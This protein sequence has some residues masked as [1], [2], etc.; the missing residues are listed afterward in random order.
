MGQKLLGLVVGAS[1]IAGASFGDGVGA[2]VVKDKPPVATGEFQLLL[3]GKRIGEERFRVFKGKKDYRV[4]STITLYWPGPSQQQYEWKLDRSFQPDELTHNLMEGGKLVTVEL[5][6]KGKNW[7]SEVKGKGIKKV[8]QD[9]G[10]R[11]HAEID[12]GSPIFQWITFRHL[13]LVAGE[14]VGVDVILLE[15]SDPT[16]KRIKR[17]YTRLPDEDVET[18]VHGQVVASVYEITQTESSY[19]LWLDPSGFPIRSERETPEGPLEFRLVRFQK[20]PRAW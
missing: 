8:K 6:K 7:R 19:R 1:V 12:F 15:T 11:Q 2:A 4:E 5:R 10:Q 14:R 18:D 17:T 3:V 20:D 16:V 9:M 13:K